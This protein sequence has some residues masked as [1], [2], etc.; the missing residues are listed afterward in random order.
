M[1]WGILFLSSLRWTYGEPLSNLFRSNFLFEATFVYF[2]QQQS[3][4]AF[5]SLKMS[6][7]RPVGDVES[8][9]NRFFW[10]YHVKQL[11]KFISEL[12]IKQ[13]LFSLS[14][15]DCDA[16]TCFIAHFRITFVM[17]LLVEKS[18]AF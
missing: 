13:S 15:A 8:T 5:D 3:S 18:I 11:S 6:A 2:S 1:H 12:R 7:F 9:E 16:L 14:L 10:S 17:L 4:A